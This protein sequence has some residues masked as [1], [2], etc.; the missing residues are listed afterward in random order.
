MAFFQIESERKAPSLTVSQTS[1]RAHPRFFLQGTAV[2]RILPYGPDVLGALLDL[3]EGGCGIEIGIAIPAQ[4]G[5]RVSLDLNAHG[6]TLKRTGI[7]RRI[8]VIRRSEKETQ[9]GIEFIETSVQR[10]GQVD[11]SVNKLLGQLETDRDRS[12]DAFGAP[13]RIVQDEYE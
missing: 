12:V 10:A 1:R 13:R 6:V 2:I 9:V 8:N 4:V 7:I 3:S 5:A 11:Y